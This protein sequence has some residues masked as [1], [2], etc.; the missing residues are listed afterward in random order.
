MRSIYSQA[1]K[2]VHNGHSAR[3][4]VLRSLGHF[5]PIGYSQWKKVD[6]LF[7]SRR[8]GN[9]ITDVLDEML[10]KDLPLN[11]KES[12]GATGRTLIELAATTQC[13]PALLHLL[14]KDPTLVTAAGTTLQVCRM[15]PRA[16]AYL[17]ES[18]YT[19]EHEVDGGSRLT[20]LFFSNGNVESF[21]LLAGVGLD[22]GINFSRGGS[23]RS[24]ISHCTLS[25]DPEF[26]EVF[27]KAGADIR[28]QEKG[29]NSLYHL[30][31]DDPESSPSQRLDALEPTELLRARVSVLQAGGLPIDTVNDAG[32]T[33]LH[34][35]LKRGYANKA[36]ALLELGASPDLLDKKGRTP[37]K[38]ARA[39]HRK[40][41]AEQFGNA[42]GAYRA[43]AAIRRATT[44]VA[45]QTQNRP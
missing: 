42:L 10:A 17:L 5:T 28:P 45:A 2:R 16:I 12:G 23:R 3:A 9:E 35:A 25:L 14:K 21:R 44:G 11:A 26:L 43:L 29:G 40:E 6:E 36:I 18:G 19:L 24:A 22:L 20:E 34:Y 30:A 39:C 13:E 31:V 38:L 15:M 4:L 33:A 27:V 37:V 1:T 41:A 7:R 8:P 32:E